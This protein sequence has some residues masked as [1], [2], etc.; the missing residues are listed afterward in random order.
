M[1]AFLF[2]KKQQQ[3]LNEK[4]FKMD[5]TDSKLYLVLYIVKN[6]K[7]I[8]LRPTSIILN[9]KDFLFTRYFLKKLL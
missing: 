6:I 1:I 7:S 5:K 4:D 3:D 9:S 8:F 2:N